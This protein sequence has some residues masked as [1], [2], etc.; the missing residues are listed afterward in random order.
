MGD[1]RWAMGDPTHDHDSPAAA[2]N[3]E[4]ASPATARA[5]C[6][7][8]GPADPLAA[9]KQRRWLQRT[10]TPSATLASSIYTASVAFPGLHASPAPSGGDRLRRDDDVCPAL[11]GRPP[12]PIISAVCSLALLN[13]WLADGYL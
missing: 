4:P 13:E 7:T 3:T 2:T 12:P 1:G 10:K 9:K 5:A 11:D 8:Q 6:A